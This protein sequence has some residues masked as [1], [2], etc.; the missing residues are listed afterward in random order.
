MYYHNFEVH[1][2]VIYKLIFS[3]VCRYCGYI[4]TY[5]PMIFKAA[6]NMA[7]FHWIPHLL[8]N[9]TMTYE[10]S[11]ITKNG[12]KSL[13]PGQ[14]ALYQQPKKYLVTHAQL[15]PSGTNIVH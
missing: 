6:C 9:I 2:F 14:L 15:N 8:I 7:M 4:H 12:R 10:L 5:K 11:K 13:S 1:N 3:C